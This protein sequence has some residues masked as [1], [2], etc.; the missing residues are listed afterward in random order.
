MIVPPAGA[1]AYRLLAGRAWRT[2]WFWIVVGPVAL[3]GLLVPALLV[4]AAVGRGDDQSR[5]AQV[6]WAVILALTA[7]TTVGLLAR[8]GTTADEGGIRRVWGLASRRL[9]WSEVG[10]FSAGEG[11]SGGLWV[12]GTRDGRRF[13]VPSPCHTMDPDR[14]DALVDRLH[15]AFGID[16]GPDGTALGAMAGAA[17]GSA[18]VGELLPLTGRAVRSTRFWGLAGPMLALLLAVPAAMGIG[19]TVARTDAGR[20]GLLGWAI[21]WSVAVLGLFAALAWSGTSM[22]GRGL[23]RRFGLVSR[24]VRWS[25]LT[26]FSPFEKDRPGLFALSGDGA[27]EAAA[28]PQ[29]PAR[30]RTPRG[31]V[32]RSGAESRP[33][34]GPAPG[35]R[36]RPG[37]TATMA[38]LDRSLASAPAHEPADPGRRPG[39]VGPGARSA[40]GLAGPRRLGRL[41]RV[42]AP[43]LAGC[44]TRPAPGRPVGRGGRGRRAGPRLRGGGLARPPIEDHRGRR[45][46]PAGLGLGRAPA[47]LGSD[48]GVGRPPELAGRA[49]SLGGADRPPGSPLSGGEPDAVDGQGERR[50]AGRFLE[51]ELGSWG[52]AVAVVEYRTRGPGGGWSAG[53]RY[54][55]MLPLL[56]VGMATPLVFFVGGCVTARR[57]VWLTTGVTV[58]LWAAW[59][60][61]AAV[62]PSG[63]IW[64]WLFAACWILLAVVPG[65]GL[66]VLWRRTRRDRWDGVPDTGQARRG[67][68]RD[69]RRPA[70]GTAVSDGVLSGSPRSTPR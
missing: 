15:R 48:P 44:R 10:G 5:S 55:W 38:D 45:R 51:P 11:M 53:P 49:G 37:R 16:P 46:C 27:P 6:V 12:R 43:L 60:A 4:H 65:V 32:G 20:A 35:R 9:A 70:G 7:V 36:R 17:R 34:A 26:G 21:A 66:F 41:R 56:S 8:S 25:E 58:D 29:C 30:P 59:I 47:G 63:G 22:N 39:P 3:L 18:A 14:A 1:E 67:R 57:W 33:G 62:G 28:G 19:S 2:R 24:A 31:R 42:A 54:C 68:R 69:R 23:R 40:G 64:T 52:L 13:Q 50:G 61:I